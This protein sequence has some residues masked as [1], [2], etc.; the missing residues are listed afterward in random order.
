MAP[1]ALLWLAHLGFEEGAQRLEQRIL[2]TMEPYELEARFVALR[3]T[4]VLG[5][6]EA[7]VYLESQGLHVQ[8]E[9]YVFRVRPTSEHA[10]FRNET[11]FLT[12]LPETPV[13]VGLMTVSHYVETLGATLPDFTLP[14]WQRL[15]YT[16][17]RRLMG[18]QLVYYDR[19]QHLAVVDLLAWGNFDRARHDLMLSG[20]L[21]FSQP[22]VLLEREGIPIFDQI[23]DVATQIGN[24]ANATPAPETAEALVKVARQPGRTRPQ[25]V[26]KVLWE[27][28]ALVHANTNVDM[29][30]CDD[31]LECAPG[32]GSGRP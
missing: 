19:D 9:R 31:V 5:A 11:P 2:M 7:R 15:A 28:H 6:E 24:P 29:S 27:P 20:A 21:D 8:S 13:G 3:T 10:K 1:D 22:L 14:Y 16:P 23:K 26:A 32:G 30:A 17:M 12:L 25:R 18:A 4:G